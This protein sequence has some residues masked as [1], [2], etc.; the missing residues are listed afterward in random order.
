MKLLTEQEISE[1]TGIKKSTLR[2]WR[3]E[4]GG[5][6]FIKVRGFMIRYPL[7]EVEEYFKRQMVVGVKTSVTNGG[8]MA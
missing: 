4:G 6:P 3:L 2:K 5:P 7:S 1:M 8:K